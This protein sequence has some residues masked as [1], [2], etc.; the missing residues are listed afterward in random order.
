MR[1]KGTLLTDY[2]RIIRANRD[3]DW[4]QWLDAGDWA[5]VDKT[6]L[7]SSWY[8]YTRFRRIAYAVFKVVAGSNFEAARSFG[9]FNMAN[10]L[11]TYRHIVVSGDPISSVRNLARL[12][13]SF[14]DSDGKIDT[15]VVEHG[16]R[17]LRF[18]YIS[19]KV[20]GCEEAREAMAHSIAGFIDET[21]ERSGHKPRDIVVSRV[22]D[23]YQMM[24]SWF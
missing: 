14:F 5:V 18:K 6:I 13:L 7:A 9:K 4:D 10:H 23:G 1:V 22:P 12:R 19:P 20:E 8:P 2:V 17:W 3:K 15:R 21:I 11:K 24:V 16:D